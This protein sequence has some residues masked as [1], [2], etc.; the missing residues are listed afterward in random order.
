M[1]KILLILVAYFGF[2]I[3]SSGQFIVSNN[4]DS[5]YIEILSLRFENANRQLQSEKKTNPNNQYIDYLENLESFLSVF[6]SEDEIL[7]NTYQDKKDSR[8]GRLKTIDENSPYK[9]YLLGN[10]YLQSA[11]AEIKFADYLSAALDFNRAYRL[12]EENT[13]KFPEFLPNQ[14]SMGVLSIMVGLVPENYRWFLNLLSIKGSVEE[15]RNSL[16]K[17]YESSLHNP[18][19]AYLRKETLFYLGFV[20]FNINPNQ[21]NIEQ[22]LTAVQQ[23]E[24]PGL[25][26][27]YLEINM[28]MKTGQNDAALLQFQE[29]ENLESYFQFSYLNY[30][31]GECYLRKLDFR[32]ANIFYKK[33][34]KEFKGKNY[35]KDAKRKQAWAAFLQGDTAVYFQLMKEVPETGNQDIDIDKEAEREAELGELPVLNLL[36]ARLLFDGGYYLEARNVLLKTNKKDLNLAQQV[37]LTYRLARIDQETGNL[38]EAKLYYEQTLLTGKNL[39]KY[40]AGNSALKLG[41]IYEQEGNIEKAR[42]YYS[43]CLKMNFDE[44]EASIHS[45]AKAGL[46]R[47]SK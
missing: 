21:E 33:F 41:E 24:D 11:F 37:E 10:V 43:T 8:I 15:G 12:I 13:E 42:E 22:L 36:K 30:L 46:E 27:S 28:L 14:I 3:N 47:V 34:E 40:F 20:D 17:V 2:A 26:L 44:Y 19:Y 7:Y 5:A 18:E 4:C 38:K 9:K 31:H 45:K 25:L 23:T 1:K 39:K 32:N 16:L 6:I 29:L 35:L